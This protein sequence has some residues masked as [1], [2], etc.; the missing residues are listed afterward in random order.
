M[1]AFLKKLLIVSVLVYAILMVVLFFMQRKFMYPAPADHP[2]LAST[3]LTMMEEVEIKS[4]DGYTVTAWWHPP[5]DGEAVV[6]F[7]HGNGSSVYDGR[8]IYQYLI[9]EGFGVLGAE[10]P[11]YPFATGSPS[12]RGLVNAALAQY[13]FV[14]E[15]GVLADNI[16]LYGTSLGAA[17]SAQ[18]ASQRGVGKIVM[19]APFNSMM[20]MV[21]LRMPL[22]AIPPMI[23]DKYYSDAALKDVAVPMLWIHGTKDQVIPITQG[24]KLYDG[25]QGPKES[26]IIQGG[27]HNN[28]WISGG[29]DAIAAF[30]KR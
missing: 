14:K 11:G 29:Q 2:K 10:Y 5:E 16:Y 1:I 4:I 13:D 26:L 24:Q 20:D 6:M 21:R 12:Q 15:Q 7:F 23:R 9:A 3:T 17:I 18:L 28:L 27:G 8:F 25:Y 22:F 30:L 19:E